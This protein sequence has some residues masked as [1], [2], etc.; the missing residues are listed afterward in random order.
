MSDTLVPT[1]FTPATAANSGPYSVSFYSP[2]HDM[3]DYLP[4]PARDRLG[5]LRQRIQDKH[6]LIV[7]HEVRQAAHAERLESQARLKRLTDHRS[8]GGFELGDDDGRVVAEREKLNKLTA[9]A[10]RLDDLDTL[11]A[12]QWREAGYV[13]HGIEAFLR[14]GM[15]P[16]TRLEVCETAVPSL[17][18][19]QTLAEAIAIRERRVG[20][21]QAEARK[22]EAS[23]FPS[24]RARKRLREKVAAWA[25]AGK[26]D[27][28]QLLLAADGDIQF[29]ER[30]MSVPVIGK[31]ESSSGLAATGFISADVLSES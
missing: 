31:T 12:T 16:G 20:E 18:K 7:G 8:V 5:Q 17:T 3:A 28:S 4:A 25:A 22:V 26:P 23:P 15:P 30:R 27:V 11:R 14:D 10:K 2:P 19:G 21:L 29:A 9:E 1:G 6:S 24:A 13:L